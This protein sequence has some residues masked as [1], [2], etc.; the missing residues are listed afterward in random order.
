MQKLSGQLHLEDDLDLDLGLGG[1]GGDQD[2]TRDQDTP[3]RRA[4]S[5]TISEQVR[6]DHEARDE[7]MPVGLKRNDID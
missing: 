3:E 2:A 5:V 4:G 1:W 6:R 7:R